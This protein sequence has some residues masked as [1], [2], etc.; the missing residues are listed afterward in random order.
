MTLRLRLKGN[1]KLRIL[2]NVDETKGALLEK[3]F[4]FMKKY[5]NKFHAICT[6]TKNKMQKYFPDSHITYKKL[7]INDKIFFEIPAEE[8]K[9]L[10]EKFKFNTDSF[11][12]GSFQK[13]TEGKTNLPK[14]SKGPDIFI[15]IIKD[16]HQKIIF[17]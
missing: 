5:A 4:A 8:C 12:I 17:H 6:N 10:R 1:K 13:D 3:Q 7:W 9:K 14:L 16:M 11:L 2:E 15:Q